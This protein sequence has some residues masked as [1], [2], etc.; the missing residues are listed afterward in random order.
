MAKDIIEALSIDG[1][2]VCEKIEEYIRRSLAENGAKGIVMGLSG[3]LD[4]ALLAALSV[5]AVGK[6]KVL[7]YFLQDRNSEKDS[8]DKARAIADWLGIKL[9]V[10]SIDSIMREKERGAPFFKW[11]TTL[12]KG[13]L[14][15]ISSLYYIIVGETPYMTVLRKNEIRRSKFKRFVY[16]NIMKGMEEM[17][18]G[19]CTERRVYLERIARENGLL[20]VGSG[21]KSEDLTGWFTPDGIDNMPYSPIKVLYK[22]QVKQL[23]EYV[24]VPAGT[25]KRKPSADVLKGA[26]DTLALGMSFD[27]IDII[28]YGIENNLPNELITQYGV[29][30]SQIERIRK[31]NELSAW[32]RGPTICR[33]S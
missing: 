9:I 26:D 11:L 24:G 2:S 22:T 21:N 15:F 18:D 19:P 8:L 27:K 33:A 10:E 29:T 14:P 31:I 5:R 16:D 3:G 28:L 13:T 12:P 25:L 30:V 4:S 1:K 32:R 20:I 7:A 23:S 6:E 17:F